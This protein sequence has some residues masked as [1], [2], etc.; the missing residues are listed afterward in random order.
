MLEMRLFLADRARA[1]Q[2]HDANP[3]RNGSFYPSTVCIQQFEVVSF[4]TFTC[5]L[6]CLIGL[7][8]PYRDS[9][10]LTRRL[11]TQCAAWTAL[12][13]LRRE[14]D[15]DDLVFAIVDGGRPTTTDA[16]F[17]AGRLFGLPID[18]K[19]TRVKSGLLLGLP[20]VI[21]T[22]GPNQINPIVLLALV[23]QLSI[24]IAGIDTMLLG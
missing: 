22:C 7:F 18:L 17:W 16:A 1:T 11:R 21:S 19:M 15:L 14:F 10:T 13:V 20:F 12:A 5:A 4:G 24:D 6:E 2:T 9:A 8:R 3:L 23:Q